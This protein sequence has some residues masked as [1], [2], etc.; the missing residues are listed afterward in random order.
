MNKYIILI[1]AFVIV[2]VGIAVAGS[3]IVSGNLSPLM[4]NIL[5]H[6]SEVAT[7]VVTSSPVA[8]PENKVDAYATE[9]EKYKNMSVGAFENL[10]LDERLL[11]P[12][13]L[14]D[15]T[16]DGGIYRSTCGDGAKYNDYIIN[17]TTVS[18]D[19]NGQDIINYFQYIQQISELQ[20]AAPANGLGEDRFN[21]DDSKKILSS[22]YYEFTSNDYTGRKAHRDELTGPTFIIDRLTATNTS[23]LLISDDEKTQ[24]KI[25]TYMDKN[26]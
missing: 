19:N 7:P 20:F 26:V 25:V 14:V 22:D 12:Q 17:P 11:Y 9:M 4:E 24:Y 16:V 13:Y 5:E 23:N 15:Q 3:V 2:V 6:R 18:R 21:V 8:T 10:S 1:A